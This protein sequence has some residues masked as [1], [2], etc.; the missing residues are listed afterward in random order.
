MGKILLFSFPLTFYPMHRCWPNPLTTELCTIR[1]SPICPSLTR[2]VCLPIKL[3]LDFFFLTLI[4]IIYNC[5]VSS[6]NP[7]IKSRPLIFTNAIKRLQDKD[8]VVGHS[9]CHLCKLCRDDLVEV[10]MDYM[11]TVFCAHSFSVSFLT[12]HF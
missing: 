1:K 2:S 11:T 6:I 8:V 7:N 4:P 12:R 5:I 3:G 10:I 9:Q